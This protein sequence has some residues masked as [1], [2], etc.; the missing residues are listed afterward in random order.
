ML[1][2]R[3]PCVLENS[4]PLSTASSKLLTS[5]LPDA[6]AICVQR[7]AGVGL[8]ASVAS[9]VLKLCLWLRTG[10]GF[11]ICWSSPEYWHSLS[12]VTLLL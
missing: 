11:L 4:G 7:R 9:C 1:I 10:H 6:G 5:L 2:W 3:T 12:L 8:G